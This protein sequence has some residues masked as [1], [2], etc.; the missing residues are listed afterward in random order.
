MSD[1]R[2]AP[3]RLLWIIVPF[4]TGA[5]IADAL[6][7]RVES[8]RIG[9]T[10]AAWLIW[11]V[12]LTA[13]MIPRV[14]TLSVVRVI[15][16]A[17]SPAAI[18]AAWVADVDTP[19]IIGVAVAL[20]A[21]FAAMLAPVGSAFVNGSSY[22]D[23]RRLPLRAPTLVGLVVAPATWAVSVAG[24]VAGPMLFMAHRWIAGLIV[25]AIGW[26]IVAIAARALH[27]LARRWVVFVPA[28]FVLHD[29]LSLNEPVL[30]TRADIV[31]LGPAPADSEARDLT[32]GAYGLALQIDFAVPVTV[33]PPGSE[34]DL[35]EAV[36]ITQFLFTPSQPGVVLAEAASR[37]IA[38]TRD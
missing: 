30:F 4:T 17:A 6:D 20:V 14:E 33:S 21:G 29:H 27:Q 5:V 36:G 3:L 9:V 23:E 34:S 2:L 19:A 13:M 32:A 10:I 28:G 7:G 25:T 26:P 8:F 22:G 24:A 37:D 15:V 31:S 1:L 16:T 18:W 38:T 11:A 35:I 12:A